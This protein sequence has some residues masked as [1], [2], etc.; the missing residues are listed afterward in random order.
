[1]NLKAVKFHPGPETTAKEAKISAGSLGTFE[2][3]AAQHG[4]YQS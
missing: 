2:N 4:E 3:G 1:M